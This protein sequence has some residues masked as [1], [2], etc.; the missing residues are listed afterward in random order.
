MPSCPSTW[1]ASCARSAC[2]EPQPKDVA[3]VF[4]VFPLALWTGSSRG[5]IS[6]CRSVRR[7]PSSSFACHEHRLDAARRHGA[8]EQRRRLDGTI[9]ARM[10]ILVDLPHGGDL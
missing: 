1:C 7:P 8:R 3:E 2:S 9:G 10:K 5:L 4:P 6:A